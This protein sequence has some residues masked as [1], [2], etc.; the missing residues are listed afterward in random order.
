[1][2]FLS[3]QESVEQP[4]VRLSRAEAVFVS[5]GLHLLL[6][7]LFLIGPQVAT[8]LLPESI[9]HML[10]PRPTLERPAVT[11]ARLA[12]AETKPPRTPKVP[13]KF[14]YVR[15]PDD[16]LVDKNPAAR[17]FSDKSRRARQEVPTPP[18]M[19]QFSIDPH[20]QGDT[21]ERIRPDPRLKDGR[22]TL[23]PPRPQQKGSTDTQAAEAARPPAETDQAK[24]GGAQKAG[25]RAGGEA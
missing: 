2:Q 21:V 4:T 18:D 10:S 3:L 12:Q 11:I 1:M 17:L 25:Q 8:R 6:L 15:T 5:V 19:K 20:S 22:D 23:E 14:T 16:N 24:G 13:L 9:I 7:L